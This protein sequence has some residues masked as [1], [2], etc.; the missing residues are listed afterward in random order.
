MSL[1]E[2]KSLTKKTL[3][4]MGFVE[5]CGVMAK[6]CLILKFKKCLNLNGTCRL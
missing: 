1:S 2:A 6:L 5:K 4:S 3:C